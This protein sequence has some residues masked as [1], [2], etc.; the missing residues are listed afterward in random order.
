MEPWQIYFEEFQRRAD[1]VAERTFERR[2][3]YAEAAHDAYQRTADLLVRE[4][5]WSDDRTLHVMRGFNAAA[6][7]WIDRDDGSWEALRDRLRDTWTDLTSGEA[8]PPMPLRA[9]PAELDE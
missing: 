4:Q 8:S 6:K 9:S 7:Q 3:A 5:Q 1:G 2:D